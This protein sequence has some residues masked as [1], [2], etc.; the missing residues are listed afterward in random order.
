MTPFCSPVKAASY[1]V[2]M[3]SSVSYLRFPLFFF[4]RY[5]QYHVIIDHAITIANCYF[6]QDKYG[7]VGLIHVDAHKDTSDHMN[8][9]LIAH[10]TPFYRAVEDGCLDT[11][12]VVQIGLRGSGYSLDDNMWGVDQVS[13]KM[14]SPWWRHAMEITG[15]LWGESTGSRWIPLTKGQWCRV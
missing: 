12:R 15:P 1:M 2:F 6:L 7:P 3:E 8:G 10:G 5:M 9:C 4:S 13:R 14:W 11:K